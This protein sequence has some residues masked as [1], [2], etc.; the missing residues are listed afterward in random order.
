MA[1]RRAVTEGVLYEDEDSLPIDLN[2]LNDEEM[3]ALAMAYA[4]A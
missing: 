2:N 3:N 1:G 4:M